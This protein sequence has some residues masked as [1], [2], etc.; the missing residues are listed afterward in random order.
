MNRA[1]VGIRV[2]LTSNVTAISVYHNSW[3]ANDIKETRTLYTAA[4][5]RTIE[6][7]TTESIPRSEDRAKTSAHQANN[8][9]CKNNPE[10]DATTTSAVWPLPVLPSYGLLG[11]SSSVRSKS[12]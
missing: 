5:L 9:E 1:S 12:G 8:D 10:P 3:R 4:G 11:G 7:W 6:R 2:C